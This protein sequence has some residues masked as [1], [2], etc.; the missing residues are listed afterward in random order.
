[1]LSTVLTYLITKLITKDDIEI[2]FYLFI[3]T[4]IILIL[5]VSEYDY[6]PAATNGVFSLKYDQM[7]FFVSVYFLEYNLNL[8]AD[9]IKL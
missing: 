6:K 4:C 7:Y 5:L 2:C 1:M 9:Q 8:S 3:F